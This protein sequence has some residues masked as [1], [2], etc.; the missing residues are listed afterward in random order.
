MT[1]LPSYQEAIAETDWLA[2]VAPYVF[3]SDY[4][5]LCLVS[6]RFWNTFA[7]RLWRDI[8]RAVRLC[9]LDPSDGEQNAQ[10]DAPRAETQLA[11]NN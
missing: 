6:G 8:L 7:P 2:L 5:S 10:S 9:G 4:R 1:A 3:F 11:L